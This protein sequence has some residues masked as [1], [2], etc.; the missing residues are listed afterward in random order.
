MNVKLIRRW[1]L[2][3]G[4]EI[5]PVGLLQTLADAAARPY[6]PAFG[7]DPAAVDRAL[8][9]ARAADNVLRRYYTRIG[10]QLEE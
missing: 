3:R 6:M 9:A 5:V 8:H 1:L 10:G 4:Y 7:G 2:P